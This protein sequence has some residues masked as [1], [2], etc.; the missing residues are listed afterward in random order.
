MRLPID[1]QA[2]PLSTR[3]SLYALGSVG[4][5]R[6]NSP[7]DQVAAW[8]LRTHPELTPLST[9]EALGGIRTRTHLIDAFILEE[10]ERAR[11]EGRTLS[12]WSLGS[13]FDARWW[14]QLPHLDDVITRYIEVETASVL[15]IKDLLLRTSPF[16]LAWSQ[17]SLRE[18]DLEQW[19]AEPEPDNRALIVAE[20]LPERL[21]LE[22]IAE[23]LQ[24]LHQHVPDATVILDAPISRVA[25]S[26]GLLRTLGWTV[27]AEHHL[28]PCAPLIARDG[29]EICPGV[30]PVRLQRLVPHRG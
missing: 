6:I 24:R 28:R 8:V 27:A 2:L 18:E 19:C 5:S 22:E 26:R 16:E 3:W 25:W 21:E 15:A 23:L 4:G 10:A 14:R 9:N 7:L 30:H 20:G 29:R 12:F 17:V 13:G 1:T 11:L